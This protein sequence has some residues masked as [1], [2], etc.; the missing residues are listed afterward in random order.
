MKKRGAGSMR[1]RSAQYPGLPIARFVIVLICCLGHSTAQSLRN[2]NNLSYPSLL[3]SKSGAFSI[4]SLKPFFLS[5]VA[6]SNSVNRTSSSASGIYPY[7]GGVG[8]GR[9]RER[10]TERERETDRER[11]EN[12][13]H[14]RH[15][16]QHPPLG[17][18]LCPQSHTPSKQQDTSWSWRR[19]AHS[20]DRLCHRL[21]SGASHI[22]AHGTYN[23]PK[24]V[25]RAYCLAKPNTVRVTVSIFH[26]L[27]GVCHDSLKRTRSYL[28]Q[29]TEAGTCPRHS[30]S[31]V[32][33]NSRAALF[34]FSGSMFASL[35]CCDNC[36]PGTCRGRGENDD[37]QS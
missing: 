12:K 4:F 20:T 22:V 1:C 32:R 2:R 7:L 14:W 27:V 11:P 5:K 17:R 13:H 34:S 15:N 30:L 23:K 26:G 18:R 6:A 24:R 31:R 10:E 29:V 21:T 16:A 37:P 28:S 19:L 36:E 25:T 9:G 3:A 8:G 35:H 33:K